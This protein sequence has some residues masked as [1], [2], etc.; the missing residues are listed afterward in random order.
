MK[1]VVSLFGAAL[2][3]A[4]STTAQV[5]ALDLTEMVEVCDNAVYGQI[6]SKHVSRLEAEDGRI[7]YF[8]TLTV[9]G[10]LLTD[11]TPVRV[12]VSYP[13]GFIN[14]NEGY[15]HSESPGDEETRVGSR[16]VAFYKWFDGMGGAHA[17][18]WLYA[19]HGGLYQSVDGPKGAMV[20]GRGQG[21]A[22]SKN[23]R[24]NDLEASVKRI[25]ADQA[26]RKNR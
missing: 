1:R 17:T 13:G 14:E 4:S 9:E 20:L 19:N 7:L 2:L 12:D 8:T 22:V 6:L 24:V 15:W 16:I 11:G 18:N 21:Y 3:L 5:R 26:R 25:R 10:R 23:L